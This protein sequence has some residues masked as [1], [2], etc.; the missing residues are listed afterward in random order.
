MSYAK[1]G[2]GVATG[3]GVRGQSART[4]WTAPTVIYDKMRLIQQRAASLD[5]DVLRNVEREA[6]RAAWGEWYKRWSAFFG[7]YQSDYAKLGAVTYT[8]E[9]NAQTDAFF[10]DIDGWYLGYMKEP[11]KGGTSIP[12]P[13]SPL[14]HVPELPKP[15]TEPPKEGISIWWFVGGAIVLGA[16]YMMYKNLKAA[17]E[18]ARA[19]APALIGGMVNPAGTAVLAAHNTAAMQVGRDP[20]P[21]M[22][23][24]PPHYRM[25][26]VP[27]GS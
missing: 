22:G 27:Y 13:T 25:V 21:P 2:L 4:G 14:P 5:A 12:P 3:G 1:V 18:T 7:K 26:A 6:F 8:D 24:L 19:I 11:G 15:G 23:Y 10:K 20:A 9:L 17:N 16:G